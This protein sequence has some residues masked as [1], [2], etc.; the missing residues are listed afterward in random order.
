MIFAEK[1]TE[2]S[3]KGEGAGAG[4]GEREGERGREGE[5]ETSRLKTSLLHVS[6]PTAPSLFSLECDGIDFMVDQFMQRRIIRASL[7]TLI[8][9]LID[10]LYPF[11]CEETFSMTFLFTHLYLLPSLTLLRCLIQMYERGWAEED[12]VC[13][14]F[15]RE[16]REREE[17]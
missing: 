2:N 6:I 8:L 10:P 3:E 4:E 17:R 16:R 7:P 11:V 9:L 14:L 1:P 13:V 5:R 12:I 15:E